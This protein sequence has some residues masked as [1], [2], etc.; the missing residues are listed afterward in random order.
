VEALIKKYP[1]IKEILGHDMVNLINRL[2][3]GPFYPLG[4]LREAILGDKQQAITSF[5][6]KENCPI[7]ENIGNQPPHQ[8]PHPEVG[9]L[10]ARS[11]VKVL[12]VH[13]HWTLV[14]V[15]ESRRGNV[16]G[17]K[18]WA[19]SSTL[20]PQGDRIKTTVDQALF[21]LIPASEVRLPPLELK[22][23]PIPA[24]HVRIQFVEGVRW[25]LVAPVLEVREDP[26]GRYEMVIPEDKVKK[27]FLEGWVERKNLTPL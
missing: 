22:V 1:T 4:E 3:P 12:E 19:L 17:Q 23:S 16:V 6:T 21:E 7:F 24:T 15:K 18:G 5:L 25:A 9:M 8:V 13:E 11:T 20:K 26:D 2:D 27:K 10:P 14:K